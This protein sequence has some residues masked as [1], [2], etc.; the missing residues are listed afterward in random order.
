V[1]QTG[2]QIGAIVGSVTLPALALIEPRLGFALIALLA[3]AAGVVF[4]GLRARYDAPSGGRSA[5]LGLTAVWQ[6]MRG[7]PGLRALAVIAAPFSAMQLTLNVFFVSLAVGQIGLS[8]LG[9]GLLMAVAQAA[10]LIGRLTWG[11]VASRAMP[12][13]RLLA[14]LGVAMAACALG[15]AAAGPGWPVAALGALVFAFGLT[16]SGWNGIFLA[17]IARLAPEGRVPDATGAVLTASYA[18]LVL[19][20]ALVALVASVASLGASFVV[21]AILTVLALPPLLRQS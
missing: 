8:H 1:R 21:L 12:A 14:L 20:P 2:N 13:R 7:A 3:V 6:L 16:A 9:A 18:G 15:V 19:G 4:V 10:G 17:E 5:P 11:V